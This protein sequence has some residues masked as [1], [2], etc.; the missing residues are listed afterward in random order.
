MRNLKSGDRHESNKAKQREGKHTWTTLRRSQWM[1]SAVQWDIDDVQ[2]IVFMH[3]FL[4][5]FNDRKAV[6][7]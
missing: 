6:H 2:L 4:L 3:L 7:V 1:M 5:S